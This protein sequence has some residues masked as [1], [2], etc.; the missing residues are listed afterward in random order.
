M[1]FN[2]RLIM[3][4]S[5]DYPT[6]DAALRCVQSF[7]GGYVIKL[8]PG[9]YCLNENICGSVDNLEIIGDCSPN[10]GV[11]YIQGARQ[12]FSVG[13]ILACAI[14]Q[15][16][17]FPP[18]RI[19]VNA[20]EISV[21]GATNPNF[22][23][24][25][26]G[27][28]VGILHVNG[29]VTDTT[30]VATRG[31]SIIVKDDPALN[32]DPFIGEG[33]FIYPDV[34]IKSEQ[35]ELRMV[36]LNTLVIQGCVLKLPFPFVAGTPGSFMDLRHN[37][38]YNLG[39]YGYYD[40]SEPNVHLGIITAGPGTQGRAL[41]QSFLGVEAR[42]VVD[43]NAGSSWYVSFFC[44]TLN[45][46]KVQNGG[47]VNLLGSGFYDN[48]LGLQVTT[49]S[50]C[51]IQGAVF[52]ANKFAMNCFY[53]SNIS[54]YMIDGNPAAGFRPIVEYNHVAFNAGYHGQIVVPNA[55]VSNNTNAFLLDTDL[56]DSV[57]ALAVGQYGKL[58]SLIIIFYNPLAPEYLS[59]IAGDP[60]PHTAA[61]CQPKLAGSYQ[62]INGVLG[63]S[64][65]I[66]ISLL[67][68]TPN[69]SS[70]GNGINSTS[71]VGT[72]TGVL[73]SSY[74]KAFSTPQQPLILTTTINPAIVLPSSSNPALM[75]TTTTSSSASQTSSL[76]L[77]S[78]GLSSNFMSGSSCPGGNC[79]GGS[80]SSSF[81]LSRNF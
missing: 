21:T 50:S 75:G 65:A 42:L 26:P 15:D 52:V 38:I 72:Y 2:P 4:P 63:S 7:K 59:S 5:D 20:R 3:V 28:K 54:S 46:C 80:S 13:G 31:N 44:A 6:L 71:G 11:G 64:S 48:L 47:V 36:P 30:I 61:D 56:I 9:E 29:V 51:T 12:P 1:S 49:Q 40:I 25:C 23:S 17:G 76:G 16:V 32:P 41:F 34:T 62:G 24:M 73:G 18:F 33:F 22:S 35:A 60:P 81:N 70:N 10:V 57:Y 8:C 66:L 14:T 45:G 27:R 43:S 79:G 67:C 37:V 39:I 77:G 68:P 78:S 69:G 55:L 58:G 53:Q 19:T 74:G